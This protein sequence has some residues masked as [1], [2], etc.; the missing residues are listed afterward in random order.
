MLR[1]GLAREKSTVSQTAE[2]DLLSDEDESDDEVSTGNSGAPA[3][4]ELELM[5]EREVELQQELQM[6]TLRCQ[7]LKST[8]QATKSF[9]EAKGGVPAATNRLGTVK[10]ARGGDT[11]I[12]STIASD[13]EEDE[14]GFD[15]ED[16]EEYDEYEEEEVI[17]YS[18]EFAKFFRLILRISIIG[19]TTTL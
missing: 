4:E 12:V 3:E 1:Y 10:P 7:E 11:H 9:I 13:E 17:V 16:A 2:D 19:G 15:E 6:A 18:I 5:H 14:D 8:L